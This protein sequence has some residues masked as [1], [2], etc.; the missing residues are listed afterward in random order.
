MHIS[1][2]VLSTPVLAGG[3]VLAAVGTAVGLRH[4]D[5]DRL[6]T[7]AILAAP[8]S[9]P[10]SSTCPSGRSAPTSS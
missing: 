5:Y 1:E 9:S 6:M 3:A 10:P 7:V 4:L 2:G 8:S